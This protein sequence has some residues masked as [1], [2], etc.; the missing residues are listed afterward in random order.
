MLS[1]GV[2]EQGILVQKPFSIIRARFF[3]AIKLLQTCTQSGIRAETPQQ[4]TNARRNENLQIP[5]SPSWGFCLIEVS[6]SLICSETFRRNS[7][8]C[9]FPTRKTWH[10]FNKK[11]YADT[12]AGKETVK[13]HCFRDPPSVFSTQSNHF[14]CT[15]NLRWRKLGANATILAAPLLFDPLPKPLIEE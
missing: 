14:T 15:S 8:T 3:D 13:K 5:P 4:I 11:A 6:W 12:D 7:T 9:S 2:A 1:I 10:I